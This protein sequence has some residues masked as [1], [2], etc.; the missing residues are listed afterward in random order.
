MFWNIA[1]VATLAWEYAC[2]A[3]V[4]GSSVGGFQAETFRL[5]KVGLLK[6]IF[7]PGLSRAS[8]QTP[9][10]LPSV[11]G[12]SLKVNQYCYVKWSVILVQGHFYVQ[13]ED[14][15]TAETFLR[16]HCSPLSSDFETIRK[17][18]HQTS[19]GTQEPS[20]RQIQPKWEAETTNTTT[21]L[22]VRVTDMGDTYTHEPVD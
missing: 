17:I 4:A 15:T 10:E 11:P 12:P 14:K 18:S 21:S 9:K 1:I 16:Y 19:R 22:K 6:P 5:S 3:A 7:N 8:G 2:T 13:S 20:T